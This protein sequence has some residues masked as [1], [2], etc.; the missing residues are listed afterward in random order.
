MYDEIQ[1][2]SGPQV[3]YGSDI[4]GNKDWSVNI[5]A[6]V[7]DELDKVIGDARETG[8]A[9]TDFIHWGNSYRALS[10]FTHGICQAL[11]SGYGFCLLRGVP[12]DRYSKDELKILLLVF[13]H[14]LGLINPQIGINIPIAEVTNLDTGAAREFYYHIGG[15][16]PP[17]MDPVD[18]AGLLCVRSAKSGGDSSI[19][20]SMAV[21]NEILKTR[22]DLLS[23]LYR[24][25][26]HLDRHAKDAG[27]RRVL[28]DHYCPIFADIGG[29]TICAYLPQP[30]LMAVEHGLVELSEP[31]T[32]AL[33][34]LNRLAT[35]PELVL[36]MALQPGDIQ[37]LNNR[38][39]L[40]HRT[41]Y[42]DYPEPDRRRLL[43]RIWLTI[44]DWKKFPGNIPRADA[45]LGSRP[46]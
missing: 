25:Y 18:V 10:E 28:T 23:L 44:K 6:D 32:E 30:I 29:E 8:A 7:L 40:H 4:A 43:L 19:V 15:P 5:P 26:Y 42:E 34:V 37:L 20:S 1:A 3:W 41:D 9:P 24:G 16:L 38:C 39:I 2:V 21:H 36:S 22:P 45:E 17:H 11:K 13:G 46:D 14:N 35:S 12:V 31:E 27:G 33:A